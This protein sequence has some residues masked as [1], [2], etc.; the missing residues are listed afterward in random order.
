MNKL[1]TLIFFL[2]FPITALAQQPVCAEQT[3]R[4]AVKN[5]TIK[6]T[7]DNFFWTGAYDKPLIGKA[8]H[9]EGKKKAD[10]EDP[11]KNQVSADHPQR[12]VVSQSGD[13]AYEYGNG[14]M[15]YDEQKSGKHVSFQIGYL[16]VWKSADGQCKVAASMIK[17]VESTIKSN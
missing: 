3:I 2:A 16:R 1:I 6:Y 11:R 4:D 13:M 17:P 14:E 5:G 12:I 7:D 15:S 10:A 9:E 8:Q